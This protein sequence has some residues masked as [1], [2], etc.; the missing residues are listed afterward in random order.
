MWLAEIVTGSDA[1]GVRFS[2]CTAG[3]GSLLG[4]AGGLC[5]L[6]KVPRSWQHVGSIN[7]VLKAWGSTRLR[8]DTFPERGSIFLFFF[9]SRKND[10]HQM[11]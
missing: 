11:L 6:L 9:L 2:G 8:C 10:T 5:C 7:V 3:R 4:L 1:Q